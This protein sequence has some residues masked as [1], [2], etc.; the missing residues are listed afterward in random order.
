MLAPSAAVMLG[1]AKLST[2]ESRR[3]AKPAPRQQTSASRSV[4]RSPGTTD[5][6]RDP[7][8]RPVGHL[9]LVGRAQ[10]ELR[11]TQGRAPDEHD[12]RGAGGDDLVG[13]PASVISPT[14]PT[15]A[16][17]AARTCAPSGTR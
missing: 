8:A 2:T 5:D 16:A 3:V 9:E 11:V 17:L 14:T 12:V 10:P 4:V 6:L 7:G 13:L 1:T 15:A